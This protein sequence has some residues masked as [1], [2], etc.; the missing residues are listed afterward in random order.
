MSTPSISLAAYGDRMLRGAPYYDLVAPAQS[1]TVDETIPARGFLII[2][3]GIIKA[4]LMNGEDRTF[5][6]GT[7]NTKVIHELALKRVWTSTTT[8]VILIAL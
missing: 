3:D 6:A 1:D 4:T 5:A 7:F 2:T 8:A